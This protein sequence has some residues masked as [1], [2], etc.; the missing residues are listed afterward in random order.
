MECFFC[1]GNLKK[2]M[3]PHREHGTYDMHECV[4]CNVGHV[5]IGNR[6]YV[7]PT[8]SLPEGAIWRMEQAY[9]HTIASKKGGS[10]DKSRKREDKKHIDKYYYDT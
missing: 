3:L 9:K 2:K 7:F 1:A 8:K 10:R 4:D 6:V 5:F